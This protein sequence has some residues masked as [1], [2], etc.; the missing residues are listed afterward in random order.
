MLHALRRLTIPLALALLLILT[1]C[2]GGQAKAPTATP[3]PTEA[4]T[5]T[6]RPTREPEPTAEPTAKPKPTNVVLTD[7]SNGNG[8]GNGSDLKPVDIGSL[9]TYAH[10]SGVFQI[11]IPSNWEIQDNSK[12]DELILIWTDPSR[13]GAVIVDIFEDSKTYSEKDLTDT[14]T[15]YLKNSFGSEPDFFLEDP[16]PQ[17]DGSILIVWT[18]TATAD[19][20][21]KAPLLGNTFIEQRGNKISLLS[22]LV[23]QDQFDSLIDKTNQIINTYKID[24]KAS[25]K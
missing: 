12:T 5:R 15:K 4:P 16:T 21:V 25:I 13:N 10:K 8:N 24:D 20:D 6:P 9:K 19:N 18:Y 2:G 23:P 17:K 7:N 22:T 11:D 3:A 14:L 1:A